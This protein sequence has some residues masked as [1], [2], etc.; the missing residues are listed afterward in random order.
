MHPSP[1]PRLAAFLAL[2]LTMAMS[3]VLVTLT[4]S[5][6]STARAAAGAPNGDVI[7][8]LFEWNWNSIA[9]ECTNHLG[10]A[11]FGGVQVS[12]PQESISLPASAVSTGIAHPW[13]EVYQPVSYNLTSRMGTRAQFA[14]MVSACHNAG[15]KVIVDAVINHMAGDDNTVT[16]D[17]GGSTWSPTGYTYN[18]PGYTYSSFHH[19]G[20]DCPEADDQIANW[21][22]VTDV[23]ECELLHLS[24]LYT[25]KSAVRSTIEG[26]LNDLISLGVDGFRVDAAKHIAQADMAAIESGLNATTWQG[27]APYIAQE[28]Y[29]GS[30]N[31]DLQYAAFEGNGS[32][33]NFDYAYDLKSAFGGGSISGLNS[34]SGLQPSA[35]SLSFV[36]NHDTERAGT[37]L[38][39]KSGSSYTLANYFVLAY[40]YGTPQVYDG[41]DWSAGDQSPPA[42][43]S[44]F[45]TDTTCGSGWECLHRSTGVTGMV[46]WHNTVGSAAVAN[47]TASSSGVIAFSR[48]AKGWIGINDTGSSYSATYTTGLPDGTYCD[49][50]TG[51][52]TTSG[53]AGTAVTVSGGSATVTI[54]AGSALAIDV[55]ALSGGG[56]A[57]AT[58]TAT[59]TTTSGSTVPVTFNEYASTAYGTNVHVTG[60]V[61]GLGNWS[62]S[63]SAAKPLSAGGYPVW[64]TT[65]SLPANTTITFKYIK[66]DSSGNVTWESNA[67]RS[68]TTGTSAATVN[69]SWNLADASATDV[70]F[71]ETATT[72][73]GNNVY[74]VG[75]IA[76]LGGWNT[77]DAIPLSAA[78]YPVWSRP[79]IVAKSTAFTYKYIKKDASGNVTWES[80]ANRSYTTGTATGYSTS[81]TWK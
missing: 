13:W 53:C 47:W 49:V 51:G 30:S 61:D 20:D 73:S 66:V 54:P 5:G 18:T 7:A 34:L 31:A 43:S 38:T 52:A 16:S 50:I 58:P 8:N 42:D 14:A 3:M 70:T 12:P 48:G 68:I 15:V 78:G 65:L 60:S 33:L 81:D 77:A 45:V 9:S 72:T 4:L 17:Y 44:G 69:D 76:A 26:Y 32:I 59:T 39:Y 19:Y 28:V 25:Q 74:V 37:T 21:D 41:F 36:T 40:P 80:G 57:T 63:T 1:R 67:N 35:K 29:P 6:G 79:V 62:T 64:S 55:S 11:G 27:T 46:G 22:S 2:A 75:S 71:K 23:Q 10:P 24:D 56:T